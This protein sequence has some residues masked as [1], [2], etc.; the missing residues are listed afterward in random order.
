ME[1]R[2]SSERKSFLIK[3][4]LIIILLLLSFLATILY[5]F[6]YP[7]TKIIMYDSDYS[8]LM[9]REVKRYSKLSSI[10]DAQKTG[11]TFLYWSY[12]D[13]G[14]EELDPNR[15]LTEEVVKLYANYQVNSYK[16]TYYIQY[17]NEELNRP[18]Y[19]TD[20]PYCRTQNYD[21]GTE[22]TLP[23]GRD[24]YN[25]IIPELES[26]QG[27]RFAGWTTKIVTE[28]DPDIDKYLRR[29]GTKFVIDVP[30]D[31]SLYAFW[32]KNTYTVNMHTGI[33]YELD[34]HGNPVK[35]ENG[36]YII[37]NISSEDDPTNEK[38]SLIQGTIKHLD[39][40]TTLTNNYSNITLNEK[41]GGIAYSEYDFKGWYLDSE[42]KISI[43]D[44]I[45]KVSIDDSGKPF[46]EYNDG[47][48]KK[49]IF[50]TISSYDADGNPI[51]EFD[52]YSKWQRRAYTIDFNKN[53]NRSNGKITSIKLYRL[54]LD[55][56]GK[57]AEEYGKYYDDGYYTYEGA[58]KGGHYS[59]VNLE[60]LDVVSQKFR[61]SN[62]K[63]RLTGWTTS[64][65]P[66]SDTE[67][68]C[69]WQQEPWSEELGK[70]RMT[71]AISY[72]Q[73]VYTH[74]IDTDR[75]LYAQWAQV[76][77]IKF[78]YASGT[79][80]KN[81]IWQGIENEWFI[82][83]DMN[84]IKDV[85]GEEWTKLHNY[86]AGWTTGTSSLATKY[87]D[88]LENGSVNPE[89]K[90][91]VGR[92]STTLIVLWQRTPYTVNFYTNDGSSNLYTTYAPVYGG[93]IKYYPTAPTREGYI[94]DGWSKT[95]Y[96]DGE[97]SQL[98][99]ENKQNG[100]VLTFEQSCYT[101]SSNFKI[102]G[103]A[104]YYASW[105]IDYVIEFDSN[106]GV[107]SNS[108]KT[109]YKY[110]ELISSTKS[111]FDLKIN[112]YIGKGITITRENYI[113]QGWNL[114]IN[115]SEVSDELIKS[116][117]TK[118]T[119]FDF[120]EMKYYDYKAE[121]ITVPE[122]S[123]KTLYLQTGNK[124]VLVAKWEPKTYQVTIYDTLATSETSR[125]R[126][127]EVAY[128]VEY[129]FP[130]ANTLGDSY[131]NKIGYK[132]L[133]FALNQDGTEGFKEYNPDSMPTIEANTLT[134]NIRYYTIYAD[135]KITVQYKFIKYAN[136]E[137]YE[138]LYNPTDSGVTVGQVPYGSTIYVLPK[139]TGTH[140][141]DSRYVFRY[142]YYLNNDGLEKIFNEG[143]KVVYHDENDIFSLYAKFEVEQYEISVSVTNPYNNAQVATKNSV[144]YVERNSTLTQDI[145]DQVME[146]V[147][148]LVDK[149]LGEWKLADGILKGFHIDGMFTTGGYSDE[150]SVGK[151]FNTDAFN[152]LYYTTSGM[153][154]ET[155]WAP[156]TIQLVYKSSEEKTADVLTQTGINYTSTIT[157]K[158]SD[159]FDYGEGVNINK[160]YIIDPSNPDTVT[161]RTFFNCSSIISGEGG[162]YKN[163]NDIIDYF[164]WDS[165]GKG[166][167]TLYASTQQTC[168][169]NYYR[170]NGVGGIELLDSVEFIYGDEIPSLIS[171]SNAIYGDMKFLGWYYKGNLVE[172]A[173]IAKDNYVVDLYAN[174]SIDVIY[175]IVK[176]E[177][178]VITK[179]LF[180]KDTIETMVGY[181]QST[182]YSYLRVYNLNTMPT[183]TDDLIPNGYIYYGLKFNENI[184][185]V[186]EINNGIDINI[187]GQN[188]TLETYYTRE[189]TITY[190]LTDNESTFEDGSTDDKTETYLVGYDGVAITPITIVHQAEKTG[191]AFNGWQ[192]RGDDGSIGTDYYPMNTSF[193]P[194]TVTTTLIP[195]FAAP[196]VGTIDVKI[197]LIRGNGNTTSREINLTN[198][199]SYTFVD[200]YALDWISAV[201]ELYK[202]TD[203]EGNE[204]LVG[205][206]FNIPV[207][208]VPGT[209][210][211]FTGV[212]LE[213]YVLNFTQPTNYAS[214]IYNE[215]TV[216][217]RTD[218]KYKTFETPII[219][220]DGIEF[221][222]WTYD[223]NGN[224]VKIY[225][226]DT[227]YVGA[228]S[229]K[230]VNLVDGTTEFYLPKPE[231]GIYGY[232]LVGNWSVVTYTVTLH[233]T[234]KTNSNTIAETIT[235]SDVPF[236]TSY[237]DREVLTS[238]VLAMENDQYGIIGW[239]ATQGAITPTVNALTDIK[240]SLVLYSVWQTKVSLSFAGETSQ[241]GYQETIPTTYHLAGETIDIN[242]VVKSIYA[243]GYTTVYFE[244]GQFKVYNNGANDYYQVVAFDLSWSD[245]NLNI[246]EDN[247]FDTFTAHT[248]SMILTPVI[249]RV[250][251]SSFYDNTTL[252]GGEEI[253]TI[254]VDYYR[255]NEVINLDSYTVSRTGFK[256]LG[257]N[258][259]K[260]AEDK[261]SNY[262]MTDDTIFY[263]IW[264]S[265]R[266]VNFYTSLTNSTGVV[267]KYNVITDFPLTK[268]NKI[269]QTSLENALADPQQSNNLQAITQ[270]QAMGHSAYQFNNK[271]LYLDGFSVTVS[272]QEKIVTIEELC[273]IDFGG[274][275]FNATE[276]VSVNIIF[277]EIYEI[278]YSTGN[279]EGV[280]GTINSPDYFVYLDNSRIGKLVNG[281]LGE[282]ILPVPTVTREYYEPLAWSTSSI[283]QDVSATRYFVDNLDSLKV[284]STEIKSIVA[285]LKSTYKQVYTLY[286][287]WQFKN[288]NTY[289]YTIADV[290]ESD[291]L[292]TTL[293]DPYPYY[294]A[295]TDGKD[296]PFANTADFIRINGQVVYLNNY[297]FNKTTDTKIAQLRFNTIFTLQLTTGLNPSVNGYSLIGWSKTLYRLGEGSDSEYYSIGSEIQ[298]IDNL[299]TDGELILYPVYALEGDVITISAING[300]A[301]VSF[302]N[303]AI[304]GYVNGIEPIEDITI[305]SNHYADVAI[306]RFTTI[307]ITASNPIS[308]SF[309]FDYF[310]GLGTTPV[311]TLNIRI[312]NGSAM[313]G[314]EHN[315]EHG[316]SVIYSAMKVK[317]SVSMQY[318]YEL[319][320]SSAD[321]AIITLTGY[322]ENNNLL[323]IN[324]SST[325]RTHLARIVSIGNLTYAV[326]NP[327]SYYT[328]YVKSGDNIVTLIDGSYI[329]LEDLSYSEEVDG[330][331]Y[332]TADLKII[333]EPITYSV[334][335]HMNK[336]QINDGVKLT[337]TSNIFQGV[338]AFEIVNNNAKVLIGSNITLPTINDI[339]YLKGGKFLGFYLN[340]DT[341][342]AYVL[343]ATI[344]KNTI[345]VEEYNDDAYSVQYIFDGKLIVVSGIPANSEYIIGLE[346]ARQV[347]GYQLECWTDEN[348]NEL[349][350]DNVKITIT[351]SY[352]L[353]AKYKGKDV[354]VKY[355]YDGNDSGKEVTIENGKDFLTLTESDLTDAI[356]SDKKYIYAWQYGENTYTPGASVKFSNLD[357]VFGNEIIFTAVYYNRYQYIMS[358]DSS[359]ISNGSNLPT[360]N[361]Y[362]KTS[363]LNG[364]AIDTN[365][366]EYKLSNVEPIN[367]SSD[368]QFSYYKVSYSLDNGANY[369]ECDTGTSVVTGSV[370][371]VIN[372]IE[373]GIDINVPVRYL[374]E[375]QFIVSSGLATVTYNI[376]N[377]TGGNLLT[378]SYQFLISAVVDGNTVVNKLQDGYL[379]NMEI[380]S[381]T[382]TYWTIPSK[383]VNFY[384]NESSLDFKKYSL[385]GYSLELLD[386]SDAVIETRQLYFGDESNRAVT[387]ASNLRLT[388]IWEENY[389]VYYYDD[390]GTEMTTL[391]EYFPYTSTEI[392]LINKDSVDKLS[393]YDTSEPNKTFVGWA[394]A[395]NK[396]IQ[397]NLDFYKFEQT[398]VVG[399]YNLYPAQSQNYNINIITLGIDEEDESKFVINS[400]LS[401]DPSYIYV[402]INDTNTINLD[403]YTYP[404]IYSLYDVTEYSF[405]GLSGSSNGDNPTNTYTLDSSNINGNN[406]NIYAV[407][408]KKSYVVTVSFEALNNA[409]ENMAEAYLVDPIKKYHN[410]DLDLSNNQDI[411]DTISSILG[412]FDYFQLEGYVI[413]E[414]ASGN[415]ILNNIYSA[416]QSGHVIVKF[417][418]VYTLQ[419]ILP[420][421]ATCNDYSDDRITISNG[422]QVEV[423]YPISN[424]TWPGYL[425]KY[426]AALRYDEV[427]KNFF[428]DNGLATINISDYVLTND[429]CIQLHLVYDNNYQ[430]SLYYMDSVED[431]VAFNNIEN[432]TEQDKRQYYKLLGTVEGKHGYSAISIEQSGEDYIVKTIFDNLIASN[433]VTIL[434][435]T[436]NTFNGLLTA[437]QSEQ[438]YSESVI[439]INDSRT[440]YAI[441]FDT[442]EG[443]FY[444]IQT[445]SGEALQNNLYLV[446]RP[447]E[448]QVN[449]Q[450]LAVNDDLTYSEELQVS[451][452]ALAEYAVTQAQIEDDGNDSTDYEDRRQFVY[453]TNT[454]YVS[455]VTMDYLDNLYLFNDKTFVRV[456]KFYQNKG[457][458]FVGWRLFDS[459]N[460]TFSD[461]S[462]VTTVN[463]ANNIINISNVRS[464]LTIV[465][466]FTEKLVNV[467]ITVAA[468]NGQ[469]HT[470][471]VNIATS[472]T[473]QDYQGITHTSNPDSTNQVNVINLQLK[474]GSWINITGIDSTQFAISTI[475]VGL[476]TYLMTSISTQINDSVID[477]DVVSFVITYDVKTTKLY[478]STY[479]NHLDIQYVGDISAIE[480]EIS[481]E[482]VTTTEIQISGDTH[483][484]ISN[485]STVLGRFN[486]S[487]KVIY[488][489]VIYAD[490]AT[491]TLNNF[492]F[493]K[494]QYIGADNN[495]YDIPAEGLTASED[496]YLIAIFTPKNVEV[497]YFVSNED[498][499]KAQING[500]SSSLVEYGQTI[501]LPY[502]VIELEDRI[503]IGWSANSMSYNW[504]DSFAIIDINNNQLASEGDTLIYEIY[505]NTVSKYYVIY[506]SG[507]SSF[508]VSN[509]PTDIAS[510]KLSSS[511]ILENSLNLEG[512]YYY[513]SLDS[514][515][516]TNVTVTL[517]NTP[518]TRENNLVIP[519]YEVTASN[520]VAFIGWASK[521]QVRYNNSDKYTY[522]LNDIVEGVITLSAI[523]SN[524]VEVQF[525]ITNPQTNDEMSLGEKVTD[526]TTLSYISTLIDKT[527]VTQV[528]I[529]N[530]DNSSTSNVTW[531]LI[532]NSSINKNYFTTNTLTDQ[533]ILDNYKFYGWSLDA[534]SSYT[535]ISSLFTNNR[536]VSIYN[537]LYK[538]KSY[539]EIYED[540]TAL[541]SSQVSGIIKLYSVWETKFQVIF[542]HNSTT[543]ASGMYGKEEIISAPTNTSNPE[544]TN[545]SFKWLG[546]SS[547]QDPTE[548]MFSGD[549][550]EF[551][552]IGGK[553]ITYQPIWEQGY[554]LKFNMNFDTIR[555]D[556]AQLMR[557]YTATDDVDAIYDRTGYPYYIGNNSIISSNSN[558]SSITIG[559]KTY[560]SE[561]FYGDLW[562]ESDK[563]NLTN[564][565]NLFSDSGIY[566]T[567][568]LTKAATWLTHYY[569]LEGWSTTP[570]GEIL[571]D[572]SLEEFA[573][574]ANTTLYAIWSPIK[575]NVYTYET[576]TQAESKGNPTDSYEINFGKNLDIDSL[577]IYTSPNNRFVKWLPVAPLTDD[578]LN[579]KK[580][581]IVNTIYLYPLYTPE[582]TVYFMTDNGSEFEGDDYQKVID[583]ETIYIKSWLED[584]LKV[585]TTLI[586]QIFTLST[587]D[588]RV[589]LYSDTEH[590]QILEEFVFNSS[591]T[592]V[593][594]DS[595]YIYIT[596]E[597]T[598]ILNI[599]K[600][601]S[602]GVEVLKSFNTNVKH[603]NVICTGITYRQDYSFDTGIYS[604]E[605]SPVLE[606]WYYSNID[607]EDAYKNNIRV[608][609]YTILPNENGYVLSINNGVHV[610]QLNDLDIN[611]YAKV[612]I[613]TTVML[614]SDSDI[615]IQKY[616]TLSYT[617][618]TGNSNCKIIS[619]RKVN[620]L[621]KGVT[622]Q[623]VFGS[624]VNPIFTIETEG[625]Y[626]SGITNLEGLKDDS[627]YT[628]SYEV[629]NT[630]TTNVNATLT[631]STTTTD[632]LDYK[633]ELK[634]QSIRA[635][636]QTYCINIAIM[637]YNVNYSYNTKESKLRYRESLTLSTMS[638]Y[639]VSGSHGTDV[640]KY[641][642]NGIELSN[643]IIPYTSTTDG[644]IC[645]ISYTNVPYGTTLIVIPLPIEDMLM[646]F[647]QW[648][649]QWSN[650]DNDN[651]TAQV[652]SIVNDN[653]ILQFFFVE[654][655]GTSLRSEYSIDAVFKFNKVQGF[656]LILDFESAEV[657]GTAWEQA[658]EAAENVSKSVNSN[659]ELIRYTIEWGPEW[660]SLITSQIYA[661]DS[662]ANLIE[663]INSAY[664]DEFDEKYDQ[665]TIS[666]KLNLYQLLQYFWYDDELQWF[667]ESKLTADKSSNGVLIEDIVYSLDGNTVVLHKVLSRAVI[668][669]LAHRTLDYTNNTPI[670]GIDRADLTLYKGAEGYIFLN[671][672]DSS[673]TASVNLTANN[674]RIKTPFSNSIKVAV[675]PAN[676]AHNHVAYK[677]DGWKFIDVAEGQ[678]GTNLIK[679]SGLDATID[680]NTTIT[681]SFISG[682]TIGKTNNIT[683]P[684][685]RLRADV[686]SET[687]VVNFINHDEN[688]IK[689][690]KIAYD[691]EIFNSNSSDYYYYNYDL[692]T[693]NKIS[694]EKRMPTFSLMQE[695][696]K[697]VFKH[698]SDS[699][700]T[701]YGDFKYIFKGW[702]NSLNS[703]TTLDI[704]NSDNLRKYSNSTYS[705]VNLYAY[706]VTAQTIDI[707]IYTSE[708]DEIYKLYL[709]NKSFVDDFNT[710]YADDT[711]GKS[712]VM[713]WINDLV[714]TSFNKAANEITGP[715][716]DTVAFYLDTATQVYRLSDLSNNFRV[717]PLITISLRITM[718]NSD[719]SNMGRQSFVDFDTL[720]GKI[721]LTMQPEYDGS[722]NLQ[723]GALLSSNVVL[724]TN[725]YEFFKYEN[726][727]AY[728]FAYWDTPS[729]QLD[730]GGKHTFYKKDR[731]NNPIDITAHYNPKV[732]IL[733]SSKGT[734]KITDSSNNTY[735]SGEY[736]SLS[737]DVPTKLN[738]TNGNVIIKYSSLDSRA[739]GGKVATLDIIKIDNG[740]NS[741]I[742]RTQ[743]SPT[744]TYLTKFA[745]TI[746]TASG[747]II[748][749]NTVGQ[750][751]TIEDASGYVDIQPVVY[752]DN[753]TVKVE[754]FAITNLPSEYT[755]GYKY[756]ADTMTVL[757]GSELVVE[758][759]D[760]MSYGNQSIMKF[761]D[762]DGVIDNSKNIT[763]TS[764]NLSDLINNLTNFRWQYLKAGVWYN[765]V[766]GQIYTNLE[767]S[768][769]YMS[770]RFAADW[771][772]YDVTF[773]QLSSLYDKLKSYDIT[774]NGNKYSLAA[775]YK[776]GGVEFSDYYISLNADN[777]I[778][779]TY[780]MLKGE[781][782]QYVFDE[783][784][785]KIS[786]AISGRQN[787]TISIYSGEGFAQGWLK[788][789]NDLNLMGLME[790]TTY[791]DVSNKSFYAWVEEKIH[792]SL[793]VDTSLINSDGDSV[794]PGYGVVSYTVT[795]PMLGTTQYDCE[796][797]KSTKKYATF[798]CGA[799]SI[800]NLEGTIDDVALHNPDELIYSC[801]E[802]G[803]TIQDVTTY[804]TG[805]SND[806]LTLSNIEAY[807]FSDSEIRFLFDANNTKSE[808][809]V[810]N[811]AQDLIKSYT[812]YGA[813]SFEYK[814][815]NSTKVTNVIIS[816]MFEKEKY[817]FNIYY[818]TNNTNTINNFYATQ[819]FYIDNVYHMEVSTVTVDNNKVT[820]TPESPNG[821]R[822]ENIGT[823]VYGNKSVG[824]RVVIKYN[825]Y[826]HTM[827]VKFLV[828]QKESGK[829]DVQY[830]ELNQSTVYLENL[831]SQSNPLSA[832]SYSITK[833]ANTAYTQYD[834]TKPGIAIKISNNNEDVI[835]TNTNYRL[836][837]AS[838]Y[839]NI[840]DR[841]DNTTSY[842]TNEEIASGIQDQ[843]SEVEQ[844]IDTNNY[845]LYIVISARTESQI[846][847][848]F[849]L[850]DK[851]AE[852]LDLQTHYTS[853]DI[854]FN[855]DTNADGSTKNVNTYT[856]NINRAVQ[857]NTQVVDDRVYINFWDGNYIIAAVS[858]RYS[859]SYDF[860][861][862]SGWWIDKSV[863]HIKLEKATHTLTY[864]GSAKAKVLEY[865]YYSSNASEDI[866]ASK[867]TLDC[868][869]TIVL[870]VRR[871]VVTVTV[872]NNYW[873][874]NYSRITSREMEESIIKSAINNLSGDVYVGPSG[875][876]SVTFEDNSNNYIRL[877]NAIITIDSGTYTIN[878]S[879]G[880]NKE[881]G[882]AVLNDQ[883]QAFT[884]DLRESNTWGLVGVSYGDMDNS[885]LNNYVTM[886]IHSY[887]KGISDTNYSTFNVHRNTPFV[888]RRSVGSQSMTSENW[889]IAKNKNTRLYSGLSSVD[890]DVDY[891][892]QSINFIYSGTYQIGDKRTLLTGY[893]ITNSTGTTISKI[894][895]STFNGDTEYLLSLTTM[896]DEIHVYP[897]WENVKVHT[898]TVSSSAYIEGGTYPVL[899]GE[900]FTWTLSNLQSITLNSTPTSTSQ[901]YSIFNEN[902]SKVFMGLTTTDISHNFQ[903]LSVSR[904][905]LKQVRGSNGIYSFTIT[906]E[907]DI[908]LKQEWN[909]VGKLVT[910]CLIEIDSDYT[911][912]SNYRSIADD[913]VEYETIVSGMGVSPEVN[914]PDKFDRGYFSVKGYYNN[915]DQSIVIEGPTLLSTIYYVVEHDDCNMKV[916]NSYTDYPENH[917]F[918]YNYTDKACSY[919]SASRTRIKG[920]ATGNASHLDEVSK[921]W[922]TSAT[923]HWKKVVCKRNCGTER[924]N[925]ETEAHE[926]YWSKWTSVNKDQHTRNCTKCGYIQAEGHNWGSYSSWTP[927]DS[928]DHERSRTCT[929]CR[930]ISAESAS[931]NNS[932]THYNAIIGTCV[933]EGSYTPSC[934]ACGFVH[935]G[936]T[937]KVG[938]NP[939]NHVGG[940]SERIITLPT[941][942]TN[943]SNE[944]ICIGCGT[945]FRG[946]TIPKLGHNCIEDHVYVKEGISNAPRR[947]Y[948]EYYEVYD[949]C[950]RC[951]YRVY[952]R[953]TGVNYVDHSFVTS[954][955]TET[956][957][958]WNSVLGMN[959]AVIITTTVTKTCTRCKYS[960][961]T[962]TTSWLGSSGSTYFK[963][964]TVSSHFFFLLFLLMIIVNLK[965]IKVFQNK[966]LFQIY[967]YNVIY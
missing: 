316:V 921:T 858:Y 130:K 821:E 5:V 846:A 315:H 347:V 735:S 591:D 654:K 412:A 876:I 896:A 285:Q 799:S 878:A 445:Y 583:G 111:Q 577:K 29:A 826:V 866:G 863:N 935:N 50:A 622:F 733:E 138:E 238:T 886:H 284:D 605:H 234:D 325:N 123:K 660:D 592:K 217:V 340:G 377:P 447:I 86:F 510:A 24:R 614:G 337:A 142:W 12:D 216:S 454:S 817:S 903:L 515:V 147:Y 584:K 829:N 378:D 25:N 525:Y 852:Y 54:I 8:I 585:K 861:G 314:G 145:Y 811:E 777:K 509:Y 657:K 942:T 755:N 154:I 440:L 756:S 181:N 480:Y 407:W 752:P 374:F 812:I 610:Y 929:L 397:T 961:T 449:L 569:Q 587:S 394:D 166:S 889:S 531:S 289:I 682:I 640:N 266:S 685:L 318:E 848:K 963:E 89:F 582:Y 389:V 64:S 894:E 251:K 836:V 331:G 413:G 391:R 938:T 760:N 392:K 554:T 668:L 140:Y 665:V 966:I 435:Q 612:T 714:G 466:V 521:S 369:I 499:S 786:T 771:I 779:V 765:I 45:V 51:Y 759:A 819:D 949:D 806:K 356:I 31:I 370:I 458:E 513:A 342:K 124:I 189:Y 946:V 430:V 256:F 373:N 573:L 964:M 232:Y 801:Y 202:W 228:D 88:K 100:T 825:E 196:D 845:T 230:E 292:D 642:S 119:T 550:L 468:T 288:I 544:I 125:V 842:P 192:V 219:N 290:I 414:D 265:T 774:I 227:I 255:N 518:F 457:Y 3:V 473:G 69:M 926:K 336:G 72:S 813:Y 778:S 736:M 464:N 662:I 955:N 857:V 724:R 26:R 136:G 631:K 363:I 78:A 294:S 951:D 879:V 415:D 443:E 382:S 734:S 700:A 590:S 616:A 98:K 421:D 820:L 782:L 960:T 431:I 351:R 164:T 854:K 880:F 785:F 321:N 66:N 867:V 63:Y 859:S 623:T 730:I 97:Y 957:Y 80:Q 535:D 81:F 723:K 269:N 99:R 693:L 379:P 712:K 909:S 740:V 408:E 122:S 831:L 791:S 297:D 680:F 881:R 77:D 104:T 769:D 649:V 403:N 688:K 186:E 767:G 133:G 434:G 75:T 800:I 455:T 362:V 520:G 139:V 112:M 764:N 650:A 539:N 709:V 538:N 530:S 704:Y 406:V 683:L 891:L 651:P 472:L 916:T 201:H 268:A 203:S 962:T 236:G 55:E 492:T 572:E 470:L 847:F 919:C 603:L 698:A 17:F 233:V 621:V 428:D 747:I 602:Q 235:L 273:A 463:N 168:T 887:E 324:L 129:T 737:S 645:T 816:D 824:N 275:G 467:E 448:Y 653:N 914:L 720:G 103:N 113:F 523:N 143:D 588:S 838:L 270:L 333:A 546:W 485:G 849:T 579:V 110:S 237:T 461:L 907:N 947:C 190:T 792:L 357:Y 108:S 469:G 327:S 783:M 745:W 44:Y 908:S 474:Y 781:T 648:D 864:E 619:V 557:T 598:V 493:V 597:A 841:I 191:Y 9:S 503:T 409:G 807:W 768:N 943:G 335:F 713:V 252:A 4:I 702:M 312:I 452:I 933:T 628:T 79:N 301:E 491:P 658:L 42:Y 690:F 686:V 967:N 570:T 286:V 519:D 82:L 707:V 160:W 442:S 692:N 418:P 311:D 798:S 871:K 206:T 775:E 601:D 840:S 664:H 141:G 39:E 675:I 505:A 725:Q 496:I 556:F 719:R 398:V 242:N 320:D 73:P 157:L 68:Y 560:Y 360:E 656:Q 632:S 298:V 721:E 205:D 766:E 948:K 46:F 873:D 450:T 349:F 330:E 608:E 536:A 58:E 528:V 770:I 593:I 163:F 274:E 870:N 272:G 332:F 481:G 624:S 626:I 620:G 673:T 918:E 199:D 222:Y 451:N 882:F 239:S 137:P 652:S 731:G 300:E 901:F 85:T 308:G 146:V 810:I 490:F 830:N 91:T 950:S 508:D 476:Y 353:Y 742:Y 526:T 213:K 856:L 1:E 460:K 150:F 516:A 895:R 843:A 367:N 931:H 419:Y 511:Y 506:S 277:Q 179:E 310:D 578:V 341:T 507:E 629:A 580:T 148:E 244:N 746:T 375:P 184:Y 182:G 368:W 772:S 102:E 52:L 517:Q 703:T 932:G 495:L 319:K 156:N 307:T 924:P 751:T 10:P 596:I 177:G 96:S 697:T 553:N 832:Y 175:N 345:F 61:D 35:D 796:L 477:N 869:A 784:T 200:N 240:S 502:V 599:P 417:S 934:S 952:K 497:R 41:N 828:I 793:L 260:D 283:D 437:L 763:A 717:Y 706:Y 352:N 267:S 423:I 808:Y 74:T 344:N 647:E 264:T 814:Y 48:T 666:N 441:Y 71:G 402:G 59:R 115:D 922:T 128:N 900:T 552:F 364:S 549:T 76:Y 109:S 117:S 281:G 49:Q 376:T 395:K 249:E 514:N 868:D 262:T 346:E 910:Y 214:A 38:E 313:F 371:T 159:V 930:S 750:T 323:E 453:P 860:I 787:Q 911:M 155:V 571:T 94:F 20:V 280:T 471:D 953:D 711:I 945:G 303:S 57:I 144:L 715:S 126:V 152:I 215:K 575:L 165:T 339:T 299:L 105:T 562:I 691:E 404:N 489:S 529:L 694:S 306:S 615:L 862:T 716:N 872:D 818:M 309:V 494:W 566:P 479:K 171:G 218:Q 958:I 13:F 18:D 221:N 169:I 823:V 563:L 802:R 671:E 174:M 305:T 855:V 107:F 158:G 501:T 581:P 83:P 40:I 293:T 173:P 927:T 348:G 350:K 446:Y 287:D 689:D 565:K 101:S 381:N 695:K 322:D 16:V 459:E 358:Y 93:N 524:Y 672:T 637:T 153:T 282:L 385:V 32:E 296:I 564:L 644:D 433:P 522:R 241:F 246:K 833:N 710:K 636:N 483:N 84:K 667:T 388:T 542:E 677:L 676:A 561:Y 263:A 744:A 11:Y 250:Y 674:I 14:G 21:Y 633:Y 805:A 638:S 574:S 776:K 7:K 708:G 416:N 176:I 794:V 548:R 47:G 643:A 630:E 343:N 941:C 959:E 33:D 484:Y 954:T 684:E 149:N 646:H 545:G 815:N 681:Q 225:V 187:N 212:W 429:Y 925:A 617:M 762:M 295:S 609:N 486:K 488:N 641:Y 913:E 804:Y 226:G 923:S 663:K 207:A 245:N 655:E 809:Y 438:Y 788:A 132:L 758:Q 208:I 151:T 504:G 211:V 162:F 897:I 258:I 728:D 844:N 902:E 183:L 543:I 194:K 773:N 606:G 533:T 558:S 372:P 276:N 65:K 851:D 850:E 500:I 754:S 400:P 444:T 134:S 210:Y 261:L 576:Q 254:D 607:Q 384:I 223:N 19:L 220:V 659:D 15:E 928:Q 27:Y 905:S 917:C 904:T 28:D 396:T 326:A 965:C 586:N 87:F 90:Y 197:T 401:L 738:I 761:K 634:F 749:L 625:Y 537:E 527:D 359:K 43:D 178:N 940:E 23:T 478:L 432:P 53:S 679:V 696:D 30:S 170:M 427:I 568:I 837:S 541:L 789:D 198:G 487:S 939:S 354:T 834:L 885:K 167:L 278:E 888:L 2:E 37:N 67:W 540:M 877:G 383:L 36:E 743:F 839:A 589:V 257:W 387:G 120:F 512:S 739:D 393:G 559:S 209:E 291:S 334:T 534:I 425:P 410:V 195:A 732:V 390:N 639:Q 875:L 753:V 669:D 899:D 726:H 699:A 727:M 365:T 741:V 328:Y 6:T 118:R 188:I 780:S 56:E 439:T 185:S 701:D 229:Y 912:K 482:K 937:I 70:A 600:A 161:N 687:Y 705:D 790:D 338:T 670:E 224:E 180:R 936:T 827:N 399:T 355:I 271:K 22:F 678:D 748:T 898:I 594:N 317:L 795:N 95:Q 424:I 259:D 366:L 121:G 803:G 835:K 729:G 595:I 611:F 883:D 127:D 114:R 172:S 661:G 279:K 915:K 456:N 253:T 822:I 722:R 462:T 60:S 551:A 247:S 34:E 547:T 116:S 532:A 944:I 193:S 131:D 604:L 302:E 613:E 329:N 618:P 884:Q 853:Q 243:K 635:N 386:S 135:K 920:T 555:S 757:G 892:Y 106:N 906:P 498:G 361:H 874:N 204:Y 718:H 380:K 405:V 865:S 411:N 62:S 422:Q 92:T 436:I 475:K 420:E 426:W 567:D 797:N 248:S 465:A 893:L 627:I 956:Q 231:D 890:E 304:T